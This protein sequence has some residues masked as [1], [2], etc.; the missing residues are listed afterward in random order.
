MSSGLE[1]GQAAPSLFRASLSSTGRWAGTIG[2]AG[3]IVAD[4]LN[5]LAPFAAYIAFAAAV[6]AFIIAA[7]IAFRL[8]LTARALPA[9]V[10][11]TSTAAIAGGLYALQSAADAEDGIIAGLVPAVA[12]L[13]DTMGIV[14]ARVERVEKAV[15][16]TK[17]AVVE[18]QR[19]ATDTKQ[20]V[21]ETQQTVEQVQRST[22]QVAKTT[23]E[24]AAGQ[25]AQQEQATR[26][27]QT[28]EA[29]KT[30]TETLVAGQETA[31]AQGEQ[32]QQTT[33]QIATSVAAI[34]QG[35]EA[36]ASQG[37]I[38][39]DPKRPDEYYHNARMHE[40]SG[41]MA[42]A[43]R[44]YMAF[45]GFGVDAVDPYIRF[46]TLLRV[47][48]GRAGA[49]EILGSLA[50]KNSALSL[51]L[52]HLLQFDDV[53]RLA[54]LNAFIEG[55]P[56]YGP[57]Y[58]LLSQEYS[59]DRLGAQTLADKRNQ[60]AALA[61]FVSFEAEGELVKD[62]VDHAEL[63]D[64]LDR[65]KTR[66]TVLG[67]VFDPQR[68]T[69]TITANRSN[70]EWMVTVSLPEP[71]TGISYRF[72][73]QQAFAETGFLAFKDQSTGQPMP[74][75]T[76]V[77]PDDATVTTIELKYRDIRGQ[78]TGPF[79]IKFDPKAELIAANKQILDQFW[80]SWVTFD[81]S[82]NKGLL[83]FTHVLSYRCAVKEMRYG[84]NGG[85][86]QKALELPACDE[87]NPYAL[88]DGYLPYMAVGDDVKT[89]SV[90]LTYADGTSSPVREFRR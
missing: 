49:R 57:A 81:A 53:Q 89:M 83:Y 75:P 13:Q 19:T 4:I 48:D 74:N 44:S 72:G 65:A 30:Q 2:L 16:E 85:P 59:E 55:N 88:P 54:K 8:V 12:E 14:A 7:A 70:Q 41:D 37:G 6:T 77:I 36:L 66:L 29:M 38:I 31:L 26:I 79:Q 56:N 58:Y 32:L 50:E 21:V 90:Q 52:V 80:T 76:F 20:A 46:A 39:A 63:A 82:G 51:K 69:P 84:F 64:W 86:P 87:K 73:G 40:L 71:S 60:A 78:E 3:G 28:T 5:P 45:A 33:E 17:E 9:L 67:D 43:R 10:F 1:L 68:S 47:Q 15:A 27:E 35:F 24:I 22:D 62:F 18:T 34:A 11:A 23:D 25:A 42:N 61:K